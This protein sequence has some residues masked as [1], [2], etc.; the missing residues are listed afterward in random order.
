MFFRLKNYV[1]D[2]IDTFW[3]IGIEN[4]KWAPV[5]DLGT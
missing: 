5:P 3:A 4:R 1:G 2:Q